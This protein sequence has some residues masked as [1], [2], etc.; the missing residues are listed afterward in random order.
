MGECPYFS[1][2]A[3]LFY[4]REVKAF[5]SVSFSAVTKFLLFFCHFFVSLAEQ[6]IVLTFEPL[7]G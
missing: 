1:V 6:W 7:F 3:N 5:S 2:G 4:L